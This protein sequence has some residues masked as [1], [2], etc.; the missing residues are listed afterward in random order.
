MRVARMQSRIGARQAAVATMEFRGLCVQGDQFA[1]PRF[2]GFASSGPAIGMQFGDGAAISA[3]QVVRRAGRRQQ[4]HRVEPSE[5]SFHDRLR[6]MVHG[7]AGVFLFVT[8]FQGFP[9]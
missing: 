1:K 2:L 8:V 5:F 9:E 3:M 4:Q 6:A 7:N